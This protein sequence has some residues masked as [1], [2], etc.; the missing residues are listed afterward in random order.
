MKTRFDILLS[1]HVEHKYFADNYFDAFE[2]KPDSNTTRSMQ[3]LGLLA[4]KIQNTW[5]L[6]Y[7]SE[8]PR[9]TDA[10]SLVNKEFTF[11]FYINDSGFEQYTSADVVP[12]PNAIQ[13]Y[14]ATI[15]NKFFSSSRFIEQA[16][17]DY[18]IQHTERPVNIK[19]KKFKGEVL[20]DVAVVEPGVKKY[21]FDVSATGEQA[22]DIS[23]NTLP[24]TDERKR[25]IFVFKNYFTNRF[26]GMIYFKVFPSTAEASNRYNLV[27]DKK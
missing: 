19:L 11:I 24:I 14:A 3:Q 2:L 7:Q 8:G 17:F 27:F 6:F 16:K 9:K 25:E 20:K 18:S 15:D 22:Y 4:K 13:F 5:Y 23:E 26:Y 10:E 12:K 21:S 1:M